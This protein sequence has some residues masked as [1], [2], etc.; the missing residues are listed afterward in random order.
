MADRSSDIE[1]L[2]AEVTALQAVLIAISRRLARDHPEIGRSICGAFDEAET[3]MSGIAVQI[4]AAAPMATTVGALRI[5][6][7]IRNAVISDESMCAPVGAEAG[8]PR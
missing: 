1:T 8:H 5:I 3:L 4:G 7:E 2:Q 6:D